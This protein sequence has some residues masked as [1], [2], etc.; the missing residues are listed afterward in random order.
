M[1]QGIASKMTFFLHFQVSLAA[2]VGEVHHYAGVFASA[3][4]YYSSEEEH[5][6]GQLAFCK[7]F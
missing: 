6:A 1:C 5:T 7:D 4:G 3:G 2:A